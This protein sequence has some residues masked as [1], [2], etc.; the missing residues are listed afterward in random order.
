MWYPVEWT[1]WELGGTRKDYLPAFLSKQ[2]Y[3][4]ADARMGLK[5]IK[6]LKGAMLSY[7]CCKFKSD[8]KKHFCYI[9]YCKTIENRKGKIKNVSKWIK[10]TK[11]EK[12]HVK[13]I[14]CMENNHVCSYL[15]HYFLLFTVYGRYFFPFIACYCLKEMF[16]GK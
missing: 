7:D 16:W 9:V 14:S 11:I 8:R 13:K 2:L 6:F 1:Y 10:M 15:P 12:C 4:Q 5:R 3:S